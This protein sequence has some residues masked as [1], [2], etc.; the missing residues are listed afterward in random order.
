L[1]KK[2]YILFLKYK[3]EQRLTL[4]PQ[5]KGKTF[6]FYTAKYDGIVNN[7]LFLFII[8]EIFAQMSI[9]VNYL[10]HTTKKYKDNKPSAATT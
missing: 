9:K 8:A 2:I 6:N 1:F 10:S 5:S 4:P 7:N 3:N